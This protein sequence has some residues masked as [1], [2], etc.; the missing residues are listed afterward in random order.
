MKQ[1][2]NNKIIYNGIDVVKELIEYN[3]TIYRRENIQFQFLDAAK[4][5]TVLPNADLLIARQILQHLD[6]KSI[7][8][9]LEKFKKYKYILITE[10]IF[11]GTNKNYN[12]DRIGNGIRD[13]GI[14][15]ELEPFNIKNT[16]TLLVIKN[17]SSNEFLRT[18][19]TVNYW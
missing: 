17:P 1:V 16:I 4:E 6:I 14:I 7:S 5:E 15:I 19:L 2:I 3:N 13:S 12:N 11:F 9:M 8:I 18:S 10:S